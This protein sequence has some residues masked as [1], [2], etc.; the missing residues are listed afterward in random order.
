MEERGQINGVGR[1]RKREE[2]GMDGG[3][4]G[5]KRWL[6]NEMTSGGEIEGKELL[7]T[8]YE[9]CGEEGWS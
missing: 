8:S 7:W 2:E 6:G 4:K 1:G 5:K 9:N 3:R